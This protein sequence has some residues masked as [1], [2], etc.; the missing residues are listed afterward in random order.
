MPT[1]GT[2]KITFLHKV[3]PVLYIVFGLS[4]QLLCRAR[5]VTPVQ[6]NYTHTNWLRCVPSSQQYNLYLKSRHYPRQID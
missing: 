5:R 2:V 1:T 3:F 6:W 4:P